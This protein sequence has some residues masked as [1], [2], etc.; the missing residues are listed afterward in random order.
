MQTDPVTFNELVVSGLTGT[1]KLRNSASPVSLVTAQDLR[2][3]P[4]SNIIEALAVQP[5]VSQL[6]TGGSISKPVIRGLGYNRVVVVN[7]GIRQEGQQWGDEHG[8]EIDGASV[9]SVEIL[10][11][12]ASLIYGSDA[13]AGV[14]IMHDEPVH[15]MGTMGGAVMAEH[16][17]NNGLLGYSVHLGGNQHGLVWDGHYSGQFAHDYRTPVDGYVPG[18]RFR[19]QAVSGMVGLNRTWGFSHLKASYYHLT[20]SLA[21]GE[22]DSLTGELE[23]DGRPYTYHHAVPFQQIRHYKVVMDNSFVAGDGTVKALLGYQLNRRQ[24][25]E[26]DTEPGLD[27]LLH[28]F[29]YDLR[30]VSPLWGGWRANVGI[31]GMGQRSMNEGDEYLIPAY[32]LFDFGLFATASRDW[33]RWHLSGGLRYDLRSLHAKGLIDD[34]QPRFTAFNRH[35]GGFSASVGAVYNVNVRTNLRANLSRGFRAPNMSEL[36]SNGEHEGTLRYE[37]GN[38]QLKPEGS[39][40]L[41][42]GADYSTKFLSMQLSLFANRISNYIFLQHD[43]TADEYHFTSGTAQLMGG[44][45]TLDIHP[46]HRLHFENSFSYVD[47]RQ[48]GVS[49]PALRYL[50]YIPPARWNATLRYDFVDNGCYMHGTKSQWL[51]HTFL[52][53]GMEHHWAQNHVHSAYGTETPTSAYT[54]WNVSLSSDILRRGRTLFTFV[55]TVQNLAN[56][57]YQNHLS[58]L[59]YADTHPL[60]GHQGIYG[61]GRNITFKVIIPF[62]Q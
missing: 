31:G 55:A 52:A 18:T 62:G 32:G 21:E 27:F 50:P 19:S 61:V 24:E 34:G 46:V 1:Q 57:A 42:V 49:D 20:P 44:E 7:D 11:G 54:L 13:M 14:L 3:R 9:H 45:A 48:T 59:K 47:A 29:T 5:G 16:H 43:A 35:F 56:V 38:S 25:Y 2:R 12:P 60:T 36:G 6:T 17:T 33:S 22:R 23:G 8:I 51:D 30:Y 39:W 4:A 15:P 58:R 26:D 10:K 28:T 40:Q 41:D 53:I 37:V